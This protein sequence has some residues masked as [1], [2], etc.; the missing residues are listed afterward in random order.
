MYA[1]HS[2]KVRAAFVAYQ[3]GQLNLAFDLYSQLA[4]DGDAQSQV[5]VAWMLSGGIGCAKDEAKAAS[6]Y[7]RAAA[8]GNP[9]GNFYY[10]RWLTM[11]GDH[12][13]AYSFYLRGAKS[14][15]L[16]SMVRT[17]HSLARGKGV[18]IDK[19]A[20]YRLLKSAALRGHAYA[21]REMAVLDMQGARGLMWIPLGLAEFVLAL[22]WGVGVSLFNKHS[23]LIRS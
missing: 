23:D 18:E 12:V 6:Y 5:F 7:Q 13:G 8:L 3:R 1:G 2:D 17:G 11:N 15:H 21:L 10:G 14:G 4:D 19:P 16:P 20:A 9:T 22:C